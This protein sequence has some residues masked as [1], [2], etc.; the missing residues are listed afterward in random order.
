M[1]VSKKQRCP[2][3][4]TIMIISAGDVDGWCWRCQARKDIRTL[5]TYW[6]RRMETS[7]RMN[8]RA[9]RALHRDLNS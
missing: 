1:V 9:R 5:R 4:D 8:E 7:L 2:H 6:R 3:C